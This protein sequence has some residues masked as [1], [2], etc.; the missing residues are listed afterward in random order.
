MEG[1]TF[2]GLDADVPD[3][4]KPFGRGM[5]PSILEAAALGQREPYDPIAQLVEQE[6]SAWSHPPEMAGWD[7]VKVGER[8]GRRVCRPNPEPSR[9][10]FRKV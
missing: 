10:S 5:P 7:C 1:R 9:S 4:G 6:T 8:S 2:V 3:P